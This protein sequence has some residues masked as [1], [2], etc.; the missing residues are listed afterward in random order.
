MTNI[1]LRNPLPTFVIRHSSLVISYRLAVKFGGPSFPVITDPC[2][3]R[4]FSSLD[5]PDARSRPC[6]FAHVPYSPLHDHFPGISSATSSISSIGLM[7]LPE[8]Y[9]HDI[10]PSGGS[11]VYRDLDPAG[12]RLEPDQVILLD[13]DFRRRT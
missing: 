12:C 13:S 4:L 10:R 11:E 1:P 7:P 6:G 5:D 3:A 9:A 2:H 8:R